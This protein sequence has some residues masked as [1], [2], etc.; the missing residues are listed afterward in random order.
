MN[1][2]LV[3][4]LGFVGAG[5]FGLTFLLPPEL[6]SSYYGIS[7]WNSGTTLIGEMLSEQEVSANLRVGNRGTFAC[8]CFVFRSAITHYE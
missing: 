6:V 1:F 4:I 7:G 3:C 2:R 8:S 5:V